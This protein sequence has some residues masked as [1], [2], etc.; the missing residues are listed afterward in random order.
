[1]TIFAGVNSTGMLR[2][3]WV[4]S[5]ANGIGT[6]VWTQ[7]GPFPFFPEGRFFHTAVYDPL[8]NTMIVFGGSTTPDSFAS[9]NNVWMLSDANGL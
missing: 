3:A 2:D 7:L 4:L 1:M 6:P 8:V 5:N 9:T